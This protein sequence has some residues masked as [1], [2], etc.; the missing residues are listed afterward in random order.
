MCLALTV[1]IINVYELKSGDHNVL[2]LVFAT[3]F[4]VGSRVCLWVGVC[5]VSTGVVE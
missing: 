2:G 5:V 4:S 1:C 3:S